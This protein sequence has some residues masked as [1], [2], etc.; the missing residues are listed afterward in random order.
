MTF[1]HQM[2]LY[3]KDKHFLTSIK[4]EALSNIQGA[5]KSDADH[6]VAL[7]PGDQHTRKRIKVIAEEAQ[8]PN[9]TSLQMPT[10]VGETMENGDDTNLE[11]E[12]VSEPLEEEPVVD[13]SACSD[14]QDAVIGDVPD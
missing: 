8:A 7:P 13:P 6:L 12:S 2:L 3:P 1:K 4:D 14:N 9:V 5:E 10:E 11:S